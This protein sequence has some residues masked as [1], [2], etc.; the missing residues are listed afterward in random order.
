MNMWCGRSLTLFA[1]SFLLPSPAPGETG[2]L[3]VLISADMEGIGG[4]V[5]GLQ[6]SPGQAEYER[7][8]KFMTGEVNAAIDAA[9]EA[10]ATEI[11]VADSHGNGQNILIE[12]LRKGARLIR[13][14]PRPLGMVEGVD[15]T[16]AAVVFIGYHASEG[17]SEGVMAHTMFGSR[18]YEL[19]LNGVPVPE[20]G[21]NAAVAGHFGVPVVAVSGD[22]TIIAELKKLLGDI[23]GAEVKR[24]IG[25]NSARVMTPEESQTLIKEKVGAA[26]RRLPDFKPYRVASPV[27]FEIS[28]KR[29]LE[30][31]ILVMLP[32]VKR[33]GS[34]TISF[35]GKDMVEVSRFFSV[36]GNV[37]PQ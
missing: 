5:S 30:A 15:E 11:V 12:E 14:W 36:V 4:T 37:N 18:I 8:R 1:L 16:F 32:G 23:E 27:A 26:L 21:F 6:V 13:S 17:A 33:L 7:F 24:A 22:Q 20:G 19:K 34:H 35:V 2:A 9:R 31:E 29:I 28:F 3:K 25:Q 10:G